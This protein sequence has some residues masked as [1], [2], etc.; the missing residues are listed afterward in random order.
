MKISLFLALFILAPFMSKEQ[1]YVPFPDSNAVWQEVLLPYPPGPMPAY[2][3]HVHYTVS[4]DTLINNTLYKKLF[5]TDFDPLCSQNFTGPYF[6][7]GIR[8]DSN[9]RK[10]YYYD[11]YTSE[12]WL[13]Y[14]FTLNVGDTV[15]PTYNNVSYP[16][17]FV[18][19]IDSVLIGNDFRKRFVYSQETYQPIQVIE[20]IGAESGLLGDMVF[21]ESIYYLRC[22]HQNDSL[23]WINPWVEFCNLETDTCLTISI[24]ER[25]SDNRLILIYP[26]PASDFI[27]LYLNPDILRPS[28]DI[29]MEIYN[30]FGEK[31]GESRVPTGQE[32]FSF[33]VSG[34]SNGLYVTVIK[35]NQRVISIEKFLIAQ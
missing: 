19:S 4:G 18:E 7:G 20:G 27:Y 33:D 6:F 17:L 26:N 11:A 25:I 23:L 1:T 30:S 34:L 5:K 9:E 8:N 15:P 28:T 21:F 35:E 22:F 10:V 24:P 32:A 13:L 31:V 14:D 16:E 29:R 3:E 12:E 2:W